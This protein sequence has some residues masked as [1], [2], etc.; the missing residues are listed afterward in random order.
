[1]SAVDYRKWKLGT[2]D[3]QITDRQKTRLKFHGPS[4]LAF[5]PAIA[6]F[7]FATV[8]LDPEDADEVRYEAP[9]RANVS[10]K[11]SDSR[12]FGVD[13]LGFEQRS[14]TCTAANCAT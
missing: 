8:A 12:R 9:R 5:V 10:G 2:D 13:G 11:Q 6:G 1:M 14:L 7:P 3:K 4:E